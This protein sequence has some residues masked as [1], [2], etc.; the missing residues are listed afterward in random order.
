MTII[1]GQPGMMITKLFLPKYYT[2]E[3]FL[4]KDKDAKEVYYFE[5]QH[6]EYTRNSYPRKIL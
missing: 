2:V 3:T 6:G 4:N 5:V 1:E